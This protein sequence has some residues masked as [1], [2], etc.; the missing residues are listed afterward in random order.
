MTEWIGVSL[1]GGIA[2]G[3]AYSW[4]R[5]PYWTMPA[6]C[7]CWALLVNGVKIMWS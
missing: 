3:A 4:W 6:M 2:I 7:A 1:V 5:L